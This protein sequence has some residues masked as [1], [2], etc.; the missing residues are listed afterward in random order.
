MVANVSEHVTQVTLT[1]TSEPSPMDI[2]ARSGVEFWRVEWT[3]STNG[4]DDQLAQSHC[5]SKAAR[6]HVD[7]LLKRRPAGV[8][9]ADVYSEQL[10]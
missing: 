2:T 6:R 7:N 9:I 5:S 8:Q 1:R 3:L 10:S 4:R